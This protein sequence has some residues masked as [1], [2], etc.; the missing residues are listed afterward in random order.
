MYLF[1]PQIL[2]LLEIPISNSS[3]YSQFYDFSLTYL[4]RSSLGPSVPPAT[5][6]LPA[7]GPGLGS[8]LP[9]CP[10]A[11]AAA[12]QYSLLLLCWT[13]LLLLLEKS[14]KD[15]EGT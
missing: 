4:S 6:S 15:L 3:L 5:A 11:Q 14:V 12:L 9:A 2:E 1:H 7:R 8:Q 13:I 10:A